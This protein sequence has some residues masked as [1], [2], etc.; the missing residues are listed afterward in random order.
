MAVELSLYAELRARVS[1]FE[2]TGDVGPL[3]DSTTAGLLLLTDQAL[4]DHPPPEADMARTVAV[5]SW[6]LHLAAPPPPVSARTLRDRALELSAWLDALAPALVPSGIRAGVRRLPRL[7]RGLARIARDPDLRLEALYDHAAFAVERYRAIRDPATLRTAIVLLR[8]LVGVTPG[9]FAVLPEEQRSRSVRAR[10]ALGVALQHELARTG[11]LHVLQAAR[12][13]SEE[14]AR[15]CAE[16]D[17]QRPLVMFNHGSLLLDAFRR[18]G[19]ESALRE[20]LE[21]SIV[22]LNLTPLHDPLRAVR[23][24]HVQNLYSALYDRSADP[25]VLLSAVDFGAEAARTVPDA[26]P[27]RAAILNNYGKDLRNLYKETRD[28]QLLRRSADALRASVAGSAAN[29]PNRISR[30]LLLTRCLLDLAGQERAG[31][32]T[33]LVAETLASAEQ[34]VRLAPP[35]HSSYRDAAGLLREAERLAHAVRQA[36]AAPAAPAAPVDPVEEARQRVRAEAP[37]S[38][39]RRARRALAGT[40]LGRYDETGDLAALAEGIELLRELDGGPGGPDPDLT[41]GEQLTWLSE[42]SQGLFQLYQRRRDLDALRDAETYARQVVASSPPSGVGRA[43]AL[44]HLGEVLVRGADRLSD[45]DA[46]VERMSEGVSCCLQAQQTCP[47]DHPLKPSLVAQAGHAV[48]GLCAGPEPHPA[49]L[50]LALALL[51]E[52]VAAIPLDAT[53]GPMV[54]I[55]LAECLQAHHRAAA[56]LETREPAALAQAAALAREAAAAVPEQHPDRVEFLL[57]LGVV[58]AVDHREA[59]AA[60]DTEH[61]AEAAAEAEE[62][63]RQAAAITTARPAARLA[64]AARAGNWAMDRGDAEAALDAFGTAVGLLPLIAPHE[65]TRRDR[66]FTLRET[67]GLASSTA[68]AAVAAGH[69]ARAVELLERARGVLAADALGTP[70]S[71]LADLRREQPELA[72]EFEELRSAVPTAFAGSAEERLRH[73][74]R[75]TRLL[76]RIRALGN[77]DFLDGATID[78]LRDAAGE[79]PV[80]L[81][82]TSAWRSDALILDPAA[83]PTEPVA[84]VPLPDLI[85]EDAVARAQR[86]QDALAALH[87][88]GGDPFAVFGAQEHAQSELHDTLEW[89]WETVAAPVLDRLGIDG[90]ADRPRPRLWWCP[91]GF[92]ASLPLHAA[93]LHRSPPPAGLRRATLLDRTVSS[94]TSTLRILAQARTRPPAS[95]GA[96]T[97]V[98]ALPQ[99]PGAEPLGH[100]EKEAARVAELLRS[101]GPVTVLTG[102]AATSQSVLDALPR[103]ATAHFVCHGLTDPLDPSGSQLLL[104][105]HRERPLTVAVLADL[106]LRE[107]DLA[108]LSACSTGVTAHRLADEFVHITAAFQLCGYRQVVGTLWPVTD[109]AAETLAEAFHARR[110]AGLPGAQALTDAL[111]DLRDRYPAA[112]TRW[113]AHVHTGV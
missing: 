108:H 33:A 1:L 91:V 84:V 23:L 78:E 85:A 3:L 110:A 9:L 83:P 86:L 20:S 38:R 53:N 31:G 55:A 111:L 25:A 54:R 96:G 103:H 97:L 17:P 69:P 34:A 18:T 113:A 95:P 6:Q 79:G 93:G 60:G 26:E 107:A 94:A 37:G 72:A 63:F 22:A 42:L 30:R 101:A 104:A 44:A 19:D 71:A 100:A 59:R 16:H 58:R 99:T 43:V 35:G 74:V 88:P 46:Y 27:Q 102:P 98:V 10:T 65:L 81:V 51:R 82:Y 64:A 36:S 15:L 5:A 70:D 67:A 8:E 49:L 57:T 41:A 14:A 47:D 80:V 48:L 89:L 112:P 52:A 12:G 105:D 40:L 45:E 87:E 66:Q 90:A 68:A 106:R 109:A 13:Y 24:C 50:E 11:E 32:N 2:D 29:D 4:R 39:S 21:V 28:L 75:W 73:G 76:G 62:A 77:A 61:A 92:L 7:R 56:V